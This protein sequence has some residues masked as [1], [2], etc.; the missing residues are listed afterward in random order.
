MLKYLGLIFSIFILSSCSNYKNNEQSRKDYIYKGKEKIELFQQDHNYKP[1][2]GY[3][4]DVETATQIADAIASKIYGKSNISK[5]KPF[6]VTNSEKY[7]KITGQI[8]ENKSNI[9]VKGGVVLII[10]DKQ[11][12]AIIRLSHGK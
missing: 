3:A 10:I 8:P 2:Y 4:S 6:I 7:W 11:S 9:A 12:G 5:Q 1:K